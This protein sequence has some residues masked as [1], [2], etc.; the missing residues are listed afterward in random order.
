MFSA[1]ITLTPERSASAELERDVARAGRAAPPA[2]RASASAGGCGPGR[3]SAGRARRLRIHTS[4]CASF[5][6]KAP[7]ASPR[8]RGPPPCGRGRCRSRRPSRRG[9]PRSSSTIRVA[10]LRRKARSWV[11]KK[12]VIFS[13]EQE[14][15]EPEDRLEVEVVG[16]L[17]EEQE[18]G[19]GR[20]RAPEERPALEPARE[21]GER[22]GR[23]QLEAVDQVVD[24]DVALP[25]LLVAGLGPQARGDDVEHGAG[26]VRRHLLGQPGEKGARLPEDVARVRLHLARD[27][28]HQRGLARAV[29]PEQA[30]ALARD[31]P[32]N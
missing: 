6:S 11:T 31:R 4:S 30:D 17:V 21:L 5:L 20:E 9:G 1:S 18:V 32:G 14:L 16:R 3:G 23:R 27:D 19:L 2:R 7:A 8:P 10:S 26:H 25:V 28:P 24:Q 12:S 13:D 29:A 15:L 22:R